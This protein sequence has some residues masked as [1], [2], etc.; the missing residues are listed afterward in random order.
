MSSGPNNNSNNASVMIPV[1]TAIITITSVIVSIANPTLIHLYASFFW[2]GI[3]SAVGI[4]LAREYKP[5]SFFILLG[6]LFLAAYIIFLL[7]DQPWIKKDPNPPPPSESAQ[8]H[9]KR[10]EDFYQQKDY[11]AALSEFD[12][13]L[14]LKTDFMQAIKYKGKCWVKIEKFKEAEDAFQ[15]AFSMAPAEMTED[16]ASLYAQWAVYWCRNGN[17]REALRCTQLAGRFSREIFEKLIV[18]IG[19]C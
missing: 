13:A 2:L 16:M 12:Q 11:L 19:N 8:A 3:L 7:R 5:T 4:L 1:V 10:G 15:K 6:C 18:E 17:S 9:F 14:Q